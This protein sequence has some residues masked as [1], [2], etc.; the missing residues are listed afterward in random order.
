MSSKELFN[1]EGKVALV[2]GA[3]SGL[4]SHFAE[5]L[6]NAGAKIIL[7]ARRTEELKKIQSN[8]SQESFVIE[9]D[10]NDK[11]SVLDL[12]KEVQILEKKIDIL[13]NNAGISD[14]K[15]FKEM[16]EESWLRIIETN[17]NG[18]FRV[19]KYVADSMINSKTKG[20]IINIAS[21]L[22]LR[23]GLNLTSYASAK[24]ALIQLTKSMALEL[25]RSDIRV[26]ALAPG[27]ILTD[28]NKDFF[29]TKEGKGYIKNIPMQ[30][31]GLKRELDGALLLLSS[32][33]SSFMTGST[34]V[35]DGGHL[36]N[37]L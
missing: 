28:I 32:D 21:I 20:S 22:G 9:L 17:L 1:L 35:V 5:T 24:A 18:A 10:V 8:L 6:S 12:L 33:D 34:L 26:N 30:R 7:A 27:Y 37:P 13:V 3:S 25:A 11:D 23:V 31:L 29:S 19:A 14:P 4:G 15:K 36:V 2:T 16:S